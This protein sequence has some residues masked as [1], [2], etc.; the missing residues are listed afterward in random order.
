VATLDD[1]N[2]NLLSLVNNLGQVL[3]SIQTTFPGQ[4][5]AVPATSTSPGIPNQVA[6]DATHLYIC[7]GPS[8]WVRATLATF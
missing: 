8:K 1:I 4:F 2:S 6:Y 3:K 5:V 7:I